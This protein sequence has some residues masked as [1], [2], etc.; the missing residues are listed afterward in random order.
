M[1]I[2]ALGFLG[3]GFCS[4]LFTLPGFLLDFLFPKRMTR[5]GSRDSWV[6]GLGWGLSEMGV[7]PSLEFYYIF[8]ATIPPSP[9]G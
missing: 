3:F 6:G 1:S 2:L 4:T 9:K 7:K 8:F 5:W